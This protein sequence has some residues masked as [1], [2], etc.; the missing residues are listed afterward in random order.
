VDPAKPVSQ[1]SNEPESSDEKRVGSV[2]TSQLPRVW[3][4]ADDRAGNTTQSVGLAEALGWPFEHKTLVPGRLSALHN[5]LLGASRAGIDK[6]RSDPLEPP[7]PD[8]LIAAGR[9][10]AP[11]AQWVRQKS[12]GHTRLVQ[13]GRKGGDHADLFDL[14]VTPAYARLAPHPHR[15]ELEAPLHRLSEAK[16]AEARSRWEA[17]FGPLPAPRV[18]VLAG[19]SSGQY[20]LTREVARRL[21]AAVATAVLPCRGAVLATTSRRTGAAPTDAL[22]RALAEVPGSFH[23]PGDPGESPYLGML[24]WAD[25]IVVTGDSE[26]ILAE[27]VSLG[28]PVFVFDLPERASFR[29]LRFFR[30]GVV[31]GAE[32]R[33]VSDGATPWMRLCAQLVELG[34]VRPPRDLSLLHASLI[35]RGVARP[36]SEFRC[37]VPTGE[38]KPSRET[39]AVVGRVRE[40]LGA[41]PAP[42]L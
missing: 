40:L 34:W 26:S 17:A 42:P 8:L 13:L 28:R 22:R 35:R 24:A 33:A 37:P 15:I 39:D 29:V 10:T 9:R 19:G 7:W 31:R 25:C 2:Q 14:V 6:T 11:V 1:V 5:R 4:L 36:F 18:A 38:E 3:V 30:E 12:A 41:S 32:A 21:A 27:A 16:L 20:R 23:A